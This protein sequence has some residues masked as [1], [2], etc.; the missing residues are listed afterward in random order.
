MSIKNTARNYGSFAKWLHWITALLFLLAYT[1]VYY[2]HWFTVKDTPENWTA[3]QLHLS[4]GINHSVFEDPALF[5]ALGLS[6]F[7]LWVPRFITA[8]IAVHLYNIIT[9]VNMPKESPI[10]LSASKHK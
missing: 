10:P 6:P 8:I 7:W 5:L 4:I 2:R 9:K 1:A 3:L